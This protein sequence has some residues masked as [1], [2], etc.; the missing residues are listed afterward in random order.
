MRPSPDLHQLIQS[1][2]KSEKRHFK[3]HA[4]RHVI[5]KENNY[6]RL[7]DAI[8]KQADY[9]EESIKTA[10]KGEKFIGRLSS[11]KVYLYHMVMESLH[12]YHLE[13]SADSQL[14]M[15]L[16]QVEL[17][18]AKGLYQHAGK[19]LRKARKLAL[20]CEAL[21]QLL[22]VIRWEKTLLDAYSLSRKTMDELENLWD[23]EQK[24]LEQLG[25][26]NQYA[27][28]LTRVWHFASRFGDIRTAEDLKSI[29]QIMTHDL[30]KN[31]DKALSLRAKL[32]FFLIHYFNSSLQQNARA[33]HDFLSSAVALLD[34]E[35]EFRK[36]HLDVY[37][38]QL[39][40]LLGS[41]VG[42]KRVDGEFELTLEK[43]RTIP[44]RFRLKQGMV[45]TIERQ[46]INSYDTE[47]LV[48][49]QGDEVSRGLSLIPEL[50]QILE[51]QEGRLLP[52]HKTIF[53]YRIAMTYFYAGKYRLA[54]RWNNRALNEHPRQF[55]QDVYGLVLN[56]NLLLQYQTGKHDVLMYSLQSYERYVK[57]QEKPHRFEKCLHDLLTRLV[58]FGHE[59]EKREALFQQ[60]EEKLQ[61]LSNDP[62]EKAA[63][64]D[65]NYSA[66]VT[67]QLEDTNIQ[68]VF[69]QHN[70]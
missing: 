4:A 61:E 3:L 51:K 67:A 14:K 2:T 31:V 7:F 24:I 53:A 40:L 1:L 13:Y 16:H 10:F 54:S 39:G 28:M 37:A 41:F 8:S 50:E 62:F 9:N 60:F 20:N 36:E 25:N 27:Q 43:L 65:F 33:V 55:R 52:H 32:Y 35:A 34:Q 64:V 11:E 66:W 6:V 42:W 70:S 59:R 46:I 44:E 69:E 49:L 15:L 47:M 38:N 63:L 29:E 19:L 22:E 68:K 21:L 56:L 30:L 5:G 23:E 58:K 57:Q 12:L 26:Y 45:K 17:L 18:Y 48:Y